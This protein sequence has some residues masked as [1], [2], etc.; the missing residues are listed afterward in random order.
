MVTVIKS[1]KEF[2]R[3][4]IYPASGNGFDESNPYKHSIKNVSLD[5]EKRREIN[6]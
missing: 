1:S 4:R 3:G 6:G 2:C 5:L